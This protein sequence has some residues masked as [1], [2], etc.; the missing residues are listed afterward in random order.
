MQDTNSRLRARLMGALV[1][2]A[3]AADSH[4][5]RADSETARFLCEALT[6]QEEDTLRA[7]ISKVPAEKARIAPDC[8]ACKTPCG[9]NL[10]HD[11][12]LMRY[13]AEDV[14]ALKGLMISALRAIAQT[15]KPASDA[16]VL[17]AMLAALRALGDEWDVPSLLP[18]ALQLGKT[19]ENII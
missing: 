15:D 10:D 1:G 18:L 14:R 4:A 3:N 16:E 13:E 8:A 11:M 5:G 2:L 7:L 12:R 6:A 9:R 17:S 19:A